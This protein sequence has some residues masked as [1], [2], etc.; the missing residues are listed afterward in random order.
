MLTFPVCLP[1]REP[2]PLMRRTA[3]AL[4]KLAYRYASGPDHVVAPVAA[5]ARFPI[6]REIYN[7]RW[8]LRHLPT[9]VFAE[10]NRRLKHATLPILQQSLDDE[11]LAAYDAIPGHWLRPPELLRA[12]QQDEQFGWR[13]VAG[14]NPVTIECLDSLDQLHDRLP[15]L[16]EAAFHQCVGQPLSL[17]DEIAA[18]RLFLADYRSLSESLSPQSARNPR[19]SRFREKYLP[20]PVVCLRET[21]LQ[22]G[23]P[24]SLVPVALTVD[25]P[26]SAPNPLYTPQSPD[27]WQ[28]GKYYAEVADNNWHFGVSHLYRCHY[29]ME[30]YT[31]AARR[32]LSERH[33]VHVLLAP[34]LRFTLAANFVAGHYFRKRGAL[35]DT[36]YAGT[37]IESRALMSLSARKRESVLSILP[38]RD[39]TQRRMQTALAYYPWREDAL[40]W[41][42]LIQRFV[43]QF[44]RAYYPSIDDVYRDPELIEFCQELIDPGCANLPGLFSGS[45]PASLEELTLALTLALYCAGPGHSAQHF[46]MIDH[47]VYAP[48]GCEAAYAPPPASPAQAT[49]ARY[50]QTLPSPVQALENFYQVEIGHFRYD[51]FGDYREYPLGV[52]PEAA[53]A[54]AELQTSLR[55]LAAAIDTREEAA[56]KNRRY[57]YLHPSLVT[58]SVNI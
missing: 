29:I 6:H 1:T 13:R 56:P 14:A 45:V 2:F 47:Y 3:R 42:A 27:L 50:R 28:L 52:L 46:T 39:L 58:N 41:Q 53:P 34:H 57:G 25:Q 30:A 43:E 22:D 10:L 23:Q 21:R 40:A 48:T 17:R 20:A 36:M 12:F 7:L 24:P 37:L 26:G 35:Y 4:A 8:A 18:H 16:D 5:A 55:A 49:P 51:C 32:C 31:L 54:V 33:P 9:V 19:D 38:D 11:S 15:A 44:L